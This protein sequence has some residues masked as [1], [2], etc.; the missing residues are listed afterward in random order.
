MQNS[1][2]NIAI[3]M[4][5]FCCR[6][7]SPAAADARFIK[8]LPLSFC[9][10]VLPIVLLLLLLLSPILANLKSAVTPEPSSGTVTAALAGW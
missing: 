1:S 5:L 9:L 7:L 8:N 2:P 6:S 4:F 10:L 3:A